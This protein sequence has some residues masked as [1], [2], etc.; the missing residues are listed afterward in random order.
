[1][2]TADVIGVPAV[3][4]ATATRGANA[5]RAGL[6]RLHD[7]LGPPPVRILE[8]LFGLLE[9]RVL[10]AL[11]DAGVP[12]ALDRPARVAD[13]A[14]R[15]DIDGDQLDRLCRFAATRGWLRIDRR[16]RVR[17]TRVTAF[18]R[19]DHPGGWRAWVD[20]AGGPE[21]ASAVQA[22]SARGVRDPFLVANGS[23]F[24]DWMKDHPDRWS[25]FDDAMAAGSRMHALVLADAVDWSGVRHVCDVGGGTGV[26]LAALLDRLPGVSGTVLDL[27][28]VVER[29]VAHPRV[30]VLGGNMF[31]RVPAGADT[32]L[33][34]NVL[35]DWD[36]TDAARI[37]GSVAAGGGDR[38][39]VVDQDRPTVP[40]RELGVATDLLMAALT[41]G[42]RERSRAEVARLASTAG[43]RLDATVPLASGDVAHVL[44]PTRGHASAR[45]ERSR[46]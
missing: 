24:F 25:A 32:Y 5:L 12:D 40:R 34:V 8:G 14:R 15:L 21:V 42:G 41:P 13:L 36:D 9:H 27:P 26:L 29:A 18:L 35:H 2:R 17:A 39:V 30:D 46:R 7:A 37:L 28:G 38:V 6:A 31:E 20:F 43:L 44:T 16:G 11:C 3:P 33:L 23:S 45:L 1:M 19:T 10:V 4:P 22:M